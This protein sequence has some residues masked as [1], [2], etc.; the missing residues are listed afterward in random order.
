MNYAVKGILIC[1]SLIHKREMKHISHE[2]KNTERC[3]S[4]WL[5]WCLFYLY[6]THCEYLRNYATEL[7]KFLLTKPTNLGSFGLE[8]L[9]HYNNVALKLFMK[10]FLIF[11]SPLV[12]N[13]NIQ[14]FFVW[15]LA[16]LSINFKRIKLFESFWEQQYLL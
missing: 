12:E 8:S 16:N 10:L 11:L 14:F 6:Q 4:G 9:N 1:L 3:T 7:I 2:N 13:E 5:H 15:I